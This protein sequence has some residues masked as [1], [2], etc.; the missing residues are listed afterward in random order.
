MSNLIRVENIDGFSKDVRSSAFINTDKDA[1]A[2]Y[3][4]KKREKQEFEQMKIE[5]IM[6]KEELALI[7]NNLNLS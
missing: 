6:L 5:I 7:K 1:L 4:R 2:D 3:K